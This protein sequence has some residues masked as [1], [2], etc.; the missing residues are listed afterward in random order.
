MGE[1]QLKTY[2]IMYV[3]GFGCCG[4]NSNCKVLQI[5]KAERYKSSSKHWINVNN[6][7]RSGKKLATVKSDVRA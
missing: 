3:W 1:K 5:N 2:Y 7:L 6:N 4:Y